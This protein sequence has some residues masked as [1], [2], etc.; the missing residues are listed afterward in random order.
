MAVVDSLHAPCN[1]AE[2]GWFIALLQTAL[3]Q[4]LFSRQL[5]LVQGRRRDMTKEL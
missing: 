3:E 1:L 4:A 2:D 5:F